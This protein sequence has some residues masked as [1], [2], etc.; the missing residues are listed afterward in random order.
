[1]YYLMVGMNCVRKL[2]VFVIHNLPCSHSAV[3]LIVLY[4]YH[5]DILSEVEKKIDYRVCRY[6]GLPCPQVVE[7]IKQLKDHRANM[8][9]RG[10]TDRC[11]R[12]EIF[13]Q[14]SEGLQRKLFFLNYL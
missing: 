1:M 4:T 13:K 10:K 7:R 12:I 5:I 9:T 8:C 6:A 2:F 3:K 11:T 14:P